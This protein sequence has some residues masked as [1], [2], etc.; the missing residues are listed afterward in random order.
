M[1]RSEVGRRCAWEGGQ[2][3]GRAAAQVCRTQR[4]GRRAA[5]WAVDFRPAAPLES[6]RRGGRVVEPGCDPAEELGLILAAVGLGLQGQ[7][8]AARNYW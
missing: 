7:G 2:E 3:G 8:G 1:Q 6:G 5:W 4:S